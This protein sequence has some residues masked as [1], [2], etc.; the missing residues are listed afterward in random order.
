MRWNYNGK[1]AVVTGGLRG[2]GRSIVEELV[3]AGAE[4]HAFD[5]A[6]SNESVDFAVHRVNVADSKS[7]EAAVAA[8]G[9]PVQLLVNNAGI[10]RDKSIVKMTDED[11]RA[12]I[13]INLT[14]CFNVIRALAPGMRDGG[15][16]RIVN[17]TSINGIRGKFG[18][19]N[20]AAAKGGLISLTKTAAR[21]LGGKGVTV[22]A[23]APGMV[24]TEMTLALA[25][26]FRAKALAEAQ[27]PYL[28]N[29]QDIANAVLFLL[30]DAARAITGEVIKVDSGQY[31]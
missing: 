30:S 2:I 1:T 7:V 6:D 12:V 13:D 9:K 3:A 24:L 5:Y 15:Y 21:E 18:Q 11:W 17:I 10:T 20:Y 19:S 8:I 23:V 27:L 16:G 28:P 26:E 4:V 31:I 25:E 14:G 22:N 29:A